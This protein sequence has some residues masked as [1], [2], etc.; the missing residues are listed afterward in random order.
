MNDNR[1]DL[2]LHGDTSLHASLGT[3]V[4]SLNDLVSN[5]AYWD[6]LIRIVTVARLCGMAQWESRPVRSDVAMALSFQDVQIA[7]LVYAARVVGRLAGE[8]HLSE[9]QFATPAAA[10]SSSSSK[11]DVI[12][13]ANKKLE[14]IVRVSM[15]DDAALTSRFAPIFAVRDALVA[16]LRVLSETFVNDGSNPIANVI[17]QAVS[18]AHA[19]T[20]FS[21]PERDE[22]TLLFKET[23]PPGDVEI[24]VIARSATVHGLNS[25]H[26]ELIR[27]HRCGSDVLADAVRALAALRFSAA[28]ADEWLLRKE[29]FNRL[30]G[31]MLLRESD[32]DLVIA[33]AHRTGVPRLCRH[34]A[35]RVCGER[36]FEDDSVRFGL[37]AKVAIDSITNATERQL[38]L[39]H[40]LDVA[41]ADDDGTVFSQRP[42]AAAPVG[43]IGYT[44]SLYEPI[45]SLLAMPPEV[46]WPS[47]A[48]RSRL[49]S[50]HGV[51]S[52]IGVW[53][54]LVTWAM[55]KTICELRMQSILA[56]ASD[57]LDSGLFLTSAAAMLA[58]L[59]PRT[60]AHTDVYAW[61][62]SLQCDIVGCRS[63]EL[64]SAIAGALD[65]RRRSSAS[66]AL[67][68]ALETMVE[69]K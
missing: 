31:F 32:N 43:T 27:V 6:V 9:H 7:S 64:K 50:R 39:G 51:Y 19:L 16:K 68:S 4:A 49:L 58:A 48:T 56:S 46:V 34:N 12:K 57:K 1:A 60:I 15:L 61:A 11:D 10:A 54:E 20:Q 69:S 28:V 65:P 18:Q 21:S 2:L 63:E 55:S 29:I 38:S 13:L 67:L 35:C 33:I 24:S 5:A 40:A 59:S 53:R 26:C 45:N 23:L 37:H 52:V 42:T 41:F 30:G 3:S 44:C 47:H 14:W 25:W 8:N 66:Q 22:R 17:C 62:A 36:G